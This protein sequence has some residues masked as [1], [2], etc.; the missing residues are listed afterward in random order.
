MSDQDLVL[1]SRS[2]PIATITINRP[3]RLNALNL[4]TI[5]ALHARFREL[6]TEP[7]TRAVILTGAGTKAF[8]A[9][10]DIAE[11]SALTPQLA[12]QFARTGQSLGEQIDALGRPVIA[13]IEGFALGGGCELAMMCH[14]RVA[15]ARASFA[16]PEVSLGLIPGFG[17]TQ[18]LARLIGE[19]RA[20]ELITTGRRLDAETA[21]AWG[22]VNRLARER[23]ANE[24]ALA[25]AEEIAA[26]GPAA[27]RLALEAVRGGLSMPLAEAL[28]YEAALFGIVFST[29][30]MREGT[31]AFIE[32]RRPSFEGR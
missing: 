19:G 28:E 13:A 1:L 31:R 9:G 26:Q 14:L 5:Q 29:S 21:F 32:K 16:Q 10:A 11:M 8:V 3:D 24:E 23:S 4:A 27:V 20:I 2:G 6:A 7:E 17:G 30:D 25:L 18:R 22:L 15:S 12:Q